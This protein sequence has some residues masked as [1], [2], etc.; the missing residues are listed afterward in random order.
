MN[1]LSKL[2]AA[3]AAKDPDPIRIRVAES[4]FE[5]EQ[6]RVRIAAENARKARIVKKAKVH[7]ERT[8]AGIAVPKAHISRGLP[9]DLPRK[10][11]KIE[12]DFALSVQKI[13][14][15][16][17]EARADVRDYATRTIAAINNGT[18]GKRTR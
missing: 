2:F 4:A 8:K 9:Y 15:V 10:E 11:R 12:V 16:A 13:S 7:S 5:S 1:V 6:K 17:E 3:H 14:D 18:F